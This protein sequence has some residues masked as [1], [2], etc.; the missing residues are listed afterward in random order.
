MLCA[1]A[2]TEVT[3]DT[4]ERDIAFELLVVEGNALAERET[5]ERVPLFGVQHVDGIARGHHR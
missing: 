4:L 2:N 1:S 5:G 3:E